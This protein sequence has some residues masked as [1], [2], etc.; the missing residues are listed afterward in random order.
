[1]ADNLQNV[2]IPQNVWTDLYTLTGITVGTQLVVENSGDIDVYLAVQATKPDQDHN[3]Y[4]IV[5]RPPSVSVQ[6]TEGD[7]GAWAFCQGGAGKLSIS[8]PSREGFVPLNRVA[9]HDGF[10]RPIDSI[11]GAVN[12]KVIPDHPS[13]VNGYF[14]RLGIVTFLSVGSI[15]GDTQVE[16]ADVAGFSVGDALHLGS[17]PNPTEP[18]RPFITSIDIPNDVLILDRPLD[19]AFP[20]ASGAAQAIIDLTQ[21]TAGATLTSPVISRY[22]PGLNKVEHIERILL[23]MTHSLA[24]DDSKFGG[25]SALTN[26]VVVRL[27]QNG[28]I[29]TLSNWKNNGD[30]IL[31]QFDVRYS[32]RAGGGPGGGNG[33]AGRGSYNKAGASLTLD[34][35]AGDFMEIRVQDPLEDLNSF[36]IKAQGEIC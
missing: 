33:T 13:W 1:M 35:A 16:V 19:N 22:S 2:A 7:P 25:I 27:S 20:I 17:T 18:Q 11:D 12:V 6:N 8:T 36:R 14:H 34:S 23:S 10:G 30:I 9:L 32:D 5:K 29:R 31:D 28:V 3:S 15:A 4:N 26:G 21:G 24:G